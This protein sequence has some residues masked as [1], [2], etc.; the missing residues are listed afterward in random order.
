MELVAI[1]CSLHVCVYRASVETEFDTSLFAHHRLVPSGFK[2][3][4]DVGCFHAIHTFQFGAYIFQ[5][6]VSSRT[7]GCSECH[8]EFH[9]S[10]VFHINLIDHAQIVDIYGYF[11]VIYSFEHIHDAF[12]YLC[13]FFLCHSLICF[14]LAKIYLFSQTTKNRVHG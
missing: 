9:S 7:V 14:L 4:V 6:E 5:N 13:L 12:F 8:V 1:G 3:E 10:V 11:R 2:H